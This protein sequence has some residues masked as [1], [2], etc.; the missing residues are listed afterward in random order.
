MHHTCIACMRIFFLTDVPYLKKKKNL[1]KANIHK[2]VTY[3]YYFMVTE[4]RMKQQQQQKKTIQKKSNLGL[5]SRRSGFRFMQSVLHFYFLIK[6]KGRKKKQK[7]IRLVTYD[8]DYEKKYHP[9][10]Y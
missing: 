4:K 3:I 2:H 1:S 9:L 7:T 8:Y 6:K 10:N 5:I